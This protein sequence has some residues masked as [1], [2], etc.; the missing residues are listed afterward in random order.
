MKSNIGEL[1]IFFKLVLCFLYM[2]HSDHV[3]PSKQNQV[4]GLK[5]LNRNILPIQSLN[6]KVMGGA[7]YNKMLKTKLKHE[8][9]LY[10]FEKSTIGY[11]VKK[12]YKF[13]KGKVDGNQSRVSSNFLKAWEQNLTSLRHCENV[14]DNY[15]DRYRKIEYLHAIEKQPNIITQTDFQPRKIS[16][17]SQFIRSNLK[18]LSN[19]SLSNSSRKI[20]HSI[21]RVM[22]NAIIQQRVDQL[23]NNFLLNPMSNIFNRRASKL[24]D[25]I[26]TFNITSPSPSPME[27]NIY[28]KSNTI[29]ISNSAPHNYKH[30]ELSNGDTV[31]TFPSTDSTDY[32]YPVQSQL[33]LETSNEVRVNHREHGSEWYSTG[34]GLNADI[35]TETGR[36]ENESIYS[37][38]SI[39]EKNALI[40]LKGVVHDS[41]KYNRFANDQAA[42]SNFVHDANSSPYP[43]KVVGHEEQ[44]WLITAT[45]A[46]LMRFLRANKGDVHDTWMA[47]EA[48]NSWRR[49]HSNDVQSGLLS[50]YCFL[51][52]EQDESFRSM[53]SM[54]HW[55]GKSYDGC[56]TVLIRPV[57]TATAFPSDA[58]D[59]LRSV[60]FIDDVVMHQSY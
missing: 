23:E 3:D 60:I 46:E 58:N 12:I 53:K 17:N 6:I 50:T 24:S 26:P 42:I 15:M 59:Y 55:L 29:T 19:I 11:L 31:T 4:V 28:D 43:G 57:E 27:E 36:V 44:D 22:T 48:H 2:V 30:V 38:I 56:M 45:D 41:T 16:F 18:T 52:M 5:N 14:N 51:A 35:D 7:M 47:L 9:K 21:S 10:F 32:H 54:I 25:S 34:T 37:P 33:D 40:A 49:T 39:L 8:R 1:I 13:L 20:F